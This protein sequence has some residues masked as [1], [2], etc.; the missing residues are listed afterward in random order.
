MIAVAT[1]PSRSGIQVHRFRAL[2]TD[3]EIQVATTDDR[4]WA[5]CRDSTVS[6]VNQFEAKFTRFRDDSLVGRINAAAGNGEWIATDEEADRV[7]DVAG[8][9][10]RVTDGILDASALPLLRIWN[11]REK[12]AEL[13][14]P[15]VIENARSLTGWRHVEREPGRIR[16]PR[17]G[18]GIDLGGFGKEYAVDAVAGVLAMR[19]ATDF[20]V[21]FGH[22]IMARGHPPDSPFWRVGVEDARKPGAWWCTLAIN[23]RGIATSGDYVRRFIKDGRRYGHIIDPRTGVPADTGC[24]AAT[25]IAPSCLEAGVLS[26]V[27]FL[28]GAVRGL[29]MIED[30]FGV[31]GCMVMENSLAQS[32]GFHTYV[33]GG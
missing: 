15:A 33:V 14:S 20:L 29:R 6:W 1:S 30:T 25:I 12:H 26:T 19:G 11:Y 13:P 24:L 7:F 5:R 21:D 32:R 27:S 17:A 4:L 10:A 22:D 16:L 18:M 9:L 8:T 2:G 23:D 3:C 31:E 28:A